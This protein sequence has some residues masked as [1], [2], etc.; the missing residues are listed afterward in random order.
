MPFSVQET[1]ATLRTRQSRARAVVPEAI[2]EPKT[3]DEQ[4]PSPVSTKAWV[5]SKARQCLDYVPRPLAFALERR[6]YLK[7]GEPELHLLPQLTDRDRV[8]VDIGGNKGVYVLFLVAQSSRVVC[9]EPNPDLC[10]MLKDRYNRYPVDVV[11]AALGSGKR[12]GKLRIPVLAGKELHGLAQVGNDAPEIEWRGNVLDEFRTVDVEIRGLDGEG[13][14]DVGFVKIDVEG[15]ELDVVEGS[16]ET[17]RRER[18]NVLV[19]CERRH[20]GSRQDRL[21]ELMASLDYD[22]YFFYRGDL[23]RLDSF[24]PQKMQDPANADGRGDYVSN[25]IFLPR[26][27]AD[28]KGILLAA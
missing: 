2:P 10:G 26:E 21:F 27:R 8:S 13:L 1:V 25:F 24:D 20:C 18:P 4:G 14:R 28:H 9:F 5:L 22:G 17:L 12:S 11:N 15:A 3:A 23:H 19:E 16:V 7:T 6:Y